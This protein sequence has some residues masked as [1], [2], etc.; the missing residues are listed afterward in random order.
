MIYGYARVSAKAQLKGSSLEEQRAELTKQYRAFRHH[1]E[2]LMQIAEIK[3]RM[4]LEEEARQHRLLAKTIAKQS[5]FH[6]S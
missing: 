2:A 1:A 3:Q 5:G 6:I 4:G